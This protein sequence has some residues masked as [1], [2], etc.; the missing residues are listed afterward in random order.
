MASE[1]TG[2]TAS[3]TKRSL[4]LSEATP[5]KVITKKNND[6]AIGTPSRR[7]SILSDHGIGDSAISILVFLG[8]MLLP[9][10]TV[11]I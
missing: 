7:T 5:A 2:N 8:L 4:D 11:V 10:L 1:P 6:R 9:R 3:Q